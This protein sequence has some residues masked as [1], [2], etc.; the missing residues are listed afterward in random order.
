MRRAVFVSLL[1]PT[2]AVAGQARF[3]LAVGSNEGAPARSKLWFAEHDAQ[4]VADALAELGEFRSEDIS[5]L[6]APTAKELRAALGQLAQR[7]QGALDA[8]EVPLVVFYYSGH[9]DPQGLELGKERLGYGELS[10]LL[11][12]IPEGVRVAI[13]DACHS[14]ALTQVKGARPAPLDFEVPREPRADGVAIITS[15]SASEAAQESAQLGGSFFTHHLTL[16]LR[17]AADSDGD[18]RVTLS[19]SYRYAYHRTLAATSEA[20][21]APQHPTY[22]I[23]MAGK[24]EVV[25]VDL[26]RARSTLQFAAGAGRSYLVTHEKSMEVVAEVATSPEPLRVALPAGRYRV[27]RIFPAPRLTGVL[28]LPAE[29]NLAVEDRALT[30]VVAVATRSKGDSLLFRGTFASAELW[31]ASPV[32]KNFGPGYGAAVGVRQDFPHSS[33]FAALSY[34]EKSV[35][36]EGLRYRYQAAALS[37]GGAFR[38]DLGRVDLLL[39]AQAGVAFA[40]QSFSA[41][42]TSGDLVLQVG[43]FAGVVVPLRDWMALRVTLAATQH[44]FKLNGAKVGRWSV[45]M[46]SG[47]DFAL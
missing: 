24:G 31:L 25:L 20:G 42:R 33:A 18:G 7:A 34:S 43:P 19:E 22:A 30:E 44:S 45:Q 27:E 16:G 40:E 23:R 10:K 26:R 32:M 37:V 36:D 8:G 9:A 12:G 41:G 21:A 2:L 1:F 6:K 5:V 47:L 15:S 39:G 14:G 17:G 28:E 38:P 13:L 46:S 4:R 11:L 35:D 3:A 29:G